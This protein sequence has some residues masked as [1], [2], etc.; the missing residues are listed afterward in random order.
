[1]DEWTQERY[2][3]IAP[4]DLEIERWPWRYTAPTNTARQIAKRRR[5][6]VLAMGGKADDDR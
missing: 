3:P 5:D 2:G 1:M 6:L 4:S